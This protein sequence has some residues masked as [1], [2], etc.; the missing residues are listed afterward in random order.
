MD[1]EVEGGIVAAFVVK[2]VFADGGISVK[3]IEMGGNKWVG[4]EGKI[5]IKVSGGTGPVS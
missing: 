4:K 2:R 1:A 5:S 3:T